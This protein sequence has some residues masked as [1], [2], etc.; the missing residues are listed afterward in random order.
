MKLCFCCNKK[1]IH[2]CLLTTTTGGE[3]SSLDVTIKN[4]KVHTGALG[5][6]YLIVRDTEEIAELC[7]FIFTRLFQLRVEI[8]ILNMGSLSTKA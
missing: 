3:F 8:G 7:S 6:I 2:P 5:H 4:G 1:G